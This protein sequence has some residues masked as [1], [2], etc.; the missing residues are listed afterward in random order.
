LYQKR[1]RKVLYDDAEIIN[2]NPQFADMKDVFLTAYPRPRSP[3]YPAISNVLQRY[4]SKVISDPDSHIEKE[5]QSA[6]IEIERIISLT[7]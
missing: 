4:F 6:S 2:A 5:A 7:R 1:P 3:L